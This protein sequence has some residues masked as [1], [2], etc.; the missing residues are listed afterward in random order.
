MRAASFLA[1]IV[2][3]LSL[4]APTRGFA[5]VAP[6]PPAPEDGEVKAQEAVK[7]SRR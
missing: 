2:L 1:V 7:P 6:I 3:G 4:V 5:T